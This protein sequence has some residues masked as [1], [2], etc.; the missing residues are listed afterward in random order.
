MQYACRTAPAARAPSVD[1]C[2]SGDE[3]GVTDKEM[4]HCGGSS[5]TGSGGAGASGETGVRV[6]WCVC[7]GGWAKSEI[8]GLGY[9]FGVRAAG[10]VL[11][12]GV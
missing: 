9:G 7:I 1:G 10:R 8:L 4:T 5:P 3:G 2:S 6:M 11:C 12:G